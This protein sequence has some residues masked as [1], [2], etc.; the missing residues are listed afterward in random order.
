PYGFAGEQFTQELQLLSPKE[1]Y[2]NWVAGA[3]YYSAL[4]KMQPLRQPF[5]GPLGEIFY[6][7]D[8]LNIVNADLTSRSPALF[9]QGTANITART[10]LTGGVRWTHEKRQMSGTNTF[11]FGGSPDPVTTPFGPDINGQNFSDS[12]VTYRLALNQDFTAN[13]MGYVAY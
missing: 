9:A 2:Y 1:K 4:D 11:Y 3:F 8:T 13:T 7:V 12:H 5:L 6:G 10:H